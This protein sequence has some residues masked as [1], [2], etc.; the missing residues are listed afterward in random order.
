MEALLTDVRVSK[1]DFALSFYQLGTLL[2]P[3]VHT[4][5]TRIMKA[6]NARKTL[7][8]LAEGE[9]SLHELDDTYAVVQTTVPL[10]AKDSLPKEFIRGNYAKG[11]RYQLPPGHW[12]S[13]PDDVARALEQARQ[14]EGECD[15]LRHAFNTAFADKNNAYRTRKFNESFGDPTKAPEAFRERFRAAAEQVHHTGNI[16][17]DKERQT[18][19]VTARSL[20]GIQK[21]RPMTIDDVLSYPWLF[22]DIEVPR[23][24]SGNMEISWVGM[25]Y[26]HGKHF[27]GEIHTLR[28]PQPI[29]GFNLFMYR[30]EAELIEGVRKSVATHDPLAVSSY[31]PYD[32]LALRDKKLKAGAR[33]SRPRTEAVNPFAQRMGISGRLVIDMYDVAKQRYFTLARHK[34]EA[35]ARHL[36]S[37]F[38][39]TIAYKE[40]AHLEEIAINGTE[41]EKARASTTIAGYLA[42]DVRI[43]PFIASHPTMHPFISAG[44]TMASDLHVP[45]ANILHNVKSVADKWDEA[46]YAK[47]KTWHND[48]PLT[49]PGNVHPNVIEKPVDP[50]IYDGVTVSIIPFGYHLKYLVQ[51]R[52]GDVGVFGRKATDPSERV[53]MALATNA[54][55]YDILALASA[56]QNLRETLLQRGDDLTDLDVM[57]RA[58]KD[59]LQANHRAIRTQLSR[60]TLDAEK[61]AATLPPYATVAKK[62][63]DYQT[64][65]QVQRYASHLFDVSLPEAAATL[66]GKIRD[67]SRKIREQGIMPVHQD[68]HFLYTAGADPATLH[69]AGLIPDETIERVYVAAAARRENRRWVMTPERNLYYV[70][71]GHVK[72]IEDHHPNT[73][74]SSTYGSFVRLL[75]DDKKDEALRRLYEDS[76]RLLNHDVDPRLLAVNINGHY[77]LHSRGKAVTAVSIDDLVKNPVDWNFYHKRHEERTMNMLLGTIGDDAYRFTESNQGRLFP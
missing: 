32:W 53:M 33:K 71:D 44:F 70:Q 42:E 38:E 54:L 22:L 73:F 75:L 59:Q 48:R 8:K 30:D 62:L 7:E 31:T 46:F 1:N 45:A 9:A 65:L 23:Y 74:E 34:L 5:P 15:T 17:Y 57:L 52:L 2:V 69:S 36:G 29:E 18:V 14:L 20:E 51:K 12:V 35:V 16:H 68:G 6:V 55:T 49:L 25:A 63:I 13:L 64:L 28:N 40:M 61:L 37:T 76:Q 10:S 26:Q 27:E 19:D 11:L 39:K 47:T 56:H 43:L 67:L 21:I 72:G 77:H 41:A 60:G 4:F 3:A 24:A 58:V 66:R 50:G